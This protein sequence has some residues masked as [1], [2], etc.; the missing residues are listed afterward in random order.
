[1]PVFGIVLFLVGPLLGLAFTAYGMITSFD[2]IATLKSPTP[3]DLSEGVYSSL[4]GTSVGLGL[5]LIGG[6]IFVVWLLWFLKSRIAPRA[7]ST[8][9]T[10]SA[11]DQVAR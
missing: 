2:K 3:K 5:G 6:L 7:S 1:V 4:I 10:V 8:P 9:R 11:P